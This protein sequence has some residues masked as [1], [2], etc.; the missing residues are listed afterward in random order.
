MIFGLLASAVWY[1]AQFHAGEVS[2]HGTVVHV[3]TVTFAAAGAGKVFGI[4]RHRW[5]RRTSQARMMLRVPSLPPRAVGD[6]YLKEPS[7]EGAERS[8]RGR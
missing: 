7:G 6:L 2:L 8:Q 3:L 4:L 1:G 5:D